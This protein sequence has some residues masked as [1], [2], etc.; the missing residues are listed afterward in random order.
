M[1]IYSS[2]VQISLEAHTHSLPSSQIVDR[3]V[4]STPARRKGSDHL[5]KDMWN[6]SRWREGGCGGENGKWG[7]EREREWEEGEVTYLF[8]SFIGLLS[9]GDYLFLLTALISKYT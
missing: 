6:E 3:I 4:R 5:F 7:R 2:G 1:Y 8:S 9:Y